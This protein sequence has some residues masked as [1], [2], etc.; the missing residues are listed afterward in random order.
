MSKSTTENLLTVIVKAQKGYKAKLT[1]KVNDSYYDTA[2]DA[3]RH[4]V[5][6][7]YETGYGPTETESTFTM[8]DGSEVTVSFGS[9]LV[10]ETPYTTQSLATY[11]TNLAERIRKI[12]EAFKE[13]YPALD[14]SVTLSL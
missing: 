14:I 9:P 13:K 12:E 5:G 11:A 6:C 4:I 10:C 1:Y 2:Y 8:S 3:C 7:E